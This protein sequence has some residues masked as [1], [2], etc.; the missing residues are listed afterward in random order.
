MKTLSSGYRDDYWIVEVAGRVLA[1]LQRD[2]KWPSSLAIPDKDKMV[3][4]ETNRHRS[5][6]VFDRGTVG[7]RLPMLRSAL[8]M[9][10]L[11]FCERRTRLITLGLLQRSK[12]RL[13]AIARNQKET[14]RLLRNTAARGYSFRQGGIEPRT[15]SIAV[16]IV[17]NGEALGAIC[18]TYA[19]SVLTLRQ[20]TSQF[21]PFL[22]DAVEEFASSAPA[23]ELRYTA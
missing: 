5:P 20:A 1:Q 8:G 2:V 13:D 16:P 12:D 14:D 6:F 15:S 22:S 11:A 3:I 19:S 7:L 4:R 18:V 23:Q 21:L 10:Y 17:V 9:S